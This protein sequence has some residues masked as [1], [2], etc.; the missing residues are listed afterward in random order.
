[1]VMEGLIEEHRRLSLGLAI[2]NSDPLVLQVSTKPQ[3]KIRPTIIL[4]TKLY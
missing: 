4:R 2:G 1:M 3:L